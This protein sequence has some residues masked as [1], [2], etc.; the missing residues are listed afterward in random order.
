MTG[1]RF[2][3]RQIDLDITSALFNGFRTAYVADRRAYCG[4]IPPDCIVATILHKR[5]RACDVH[6]SSSQVQ[7]TR[8][9]NIRDDKQS[10]YESQ[11][12]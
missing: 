11:Y 5:R 3:A 10:G 7:R 12:G 8:R 6:M 1:L 9:V 2:F 4:R